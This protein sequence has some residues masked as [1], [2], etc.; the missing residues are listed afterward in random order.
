MNDQNVKREEIKKNDKFVICWSIIT[1]VLLV[2]IASITIFVDPFFHYH[3]PISFLQ[4]RLQLGDERYLNNGIARNFDYDALVTGSSMTENFKTSEVDELFGVV[5]V[6]VPYSGGQY[7]EIG[8]NIRRACETHPN[9]KMV[10]LSMDESRLIEDK[11]KEYTGSNGEFRYPYYLTDS[12]PFNDVEYVLNKEILLR[13]TIDNSVKFSFEKNK[14]TT[15]DE[16][17]YWNE[18]YP[19]GKEAIMDTYG[20]PDVSNTKRELTEECEALLIGNI[21]QNIIS[22]ADDYPNTEFYVFIPPYSI[23]NWDK[24]NRNGEIDYW[25]QATRLASKELV[26]HSNI[27]LFA[28]G[29]KLDIVC[30]LDNYK[31]A[32]H[33]SADINSL[34]LDFMALGEGGLCSDNVDTYFDKIYKIYSEYDYESIFCDKGE[35]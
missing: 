25:I 11:D 35:K 28:F 2:G 3:K 27:H 26:K 15:F 18:L 8:D 21:E 17:A 6:K 13:K 24:R 1:I 31:D 23:V 30:N 14:S 9:L 16:Y 29:D 33:Y 20:R 32:G 7:K 22:I 10:I 19:F 34:I 12:N 5:S 4:Y